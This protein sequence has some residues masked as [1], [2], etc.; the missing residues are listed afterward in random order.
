MVEV[1]ETRWWVSP[2]LIA[3]WWTR[4]V[5]RES[6]FGIGFGFGGGGEEEAIEDSDGQIDGFEGRFWL[7]WCW[8]WSEFLVLRIV[9]GFEAE[10]P[11][12]KKNKCKRV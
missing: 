12:G 6:A 9:M 11:I 4:G 1:R 7:W 8:C 5:E 3:G 10:Q 2:F